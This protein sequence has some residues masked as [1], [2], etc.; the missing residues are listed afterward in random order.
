MSSSSRVAGKVRP[1]PIANSLRSN[2]K[3]PPAAPLKPAGRKRSPMLWVRT[4]ETDEFLLVT[5]CAKRGKAKKE[6]A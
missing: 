1:S 6:K 3:I 2:A 5:I 4:V